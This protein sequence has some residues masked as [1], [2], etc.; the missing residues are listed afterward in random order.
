MVRLRLICVILLLCNC[1][2]AQ[3]FETKIYSDHI[4]IDRAGPRDYM[5]ESVILTIE[6]VD[7]RFPER[8]V[9]VNRNVLDSLSIFIDKVY[10]EK[11]SILLREIDVNEFGI[12]KVTIRIEDK[13]QVFYTRNRKIAIVFL[14]RV[15]NLLKDLSAP[16]E[17]IDKTEAMLQKVN[18]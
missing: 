5:L 1:C 12:F 6:K 10:K 11:P 7:L 2:H 16:D 14:T 15:R 8:P 4:R 3:L 9:K 17:S 13:A 18:Y